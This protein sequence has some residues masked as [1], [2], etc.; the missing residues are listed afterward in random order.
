MDRT[1]TNYLESKLETIKKEGLYKPEKILLSPQ[2]VNIYLNKDTPVLNFCSNNYLGLSNHPELIQEAKNALD[3][4]GYGLSSVRFICGTQSIHKE[5]EQSISLF[6]NTEDS[7]LYS[8]C[9]DANTGLFETLL[10]EE[11][12]IITDAL[13]HASIIDGIRL[14]KAK[15]EIYENRDM[16]DLEKKLIESKNSRFRLIA[17]DGVFSMDGTIAPLDKI[18]ALGKRYNAMVMVDDS[19]GIGVI[20]KNG[21]GLSEHFDLLGNVDIITGTLGK[22]LGGA[23]GGFTTG[24]KEIIEYLR[25]RS[26]PYLFSNSLSP[27]ITA[28]S[29]KAFELLTRKNTLIQTL[30]SNIFHFKNSLKNHGFE[31]EDNTFAIIPV[32]LKK[33]ENAIE[34]AY[35][36]DKENILTTAFSYPV[37]PKNKARIRLQIS[38]AH[39]KSDL[40]QV[41]G[42]IASIYKTF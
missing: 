15:K 16:D 36:L 33:A 29:I 35:Q 21:K 12:T 9:F 19:H 32:M 2:G 11:D 31:V 42:K 7:I 17:T 34:M 3:K 30:H 18:I 27:V 38:A 28:T 40:E 41:A 25:Q 24:R 5:L 1:F 14:C 37:V 20:G 13:N 23:S 22:A 4:W 39:Q 26:R 8:S 10:T 6:L